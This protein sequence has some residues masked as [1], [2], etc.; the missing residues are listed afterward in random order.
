[1]PEG[2]R[3]VDE[4]PAQPSADQQPWPYP[5]PREEW[6][7]L[8][9][10]IRAYITALRQRLEQLEARLNRNSQNSN[11]PP[12]ADSPF[13]KPASSAQ[14]RLRKPGGRK[15]H[16]GHR[17]AFLAPDRVVDYL[18]ERCRCGGTDIGGLKIYYV[19][20][21]VELPAIQPEVTHHCLHEGTC[22]TCGHTV[23]AS[24]SQ[25]PPIHQCGFGPRMT[26]FVAL[27]AGTLGASR[28]EIQRLLAD[29]FE[30]PVSLG[31]IQKSLDRSSDAVAPHHQAIGDLARAAAA[32][33]IDETSWRSQ[34]GSQVLLRWLWVM[35]NRTVAFFRLLPGRSRKDFEA[36]IGTWAGILISDDYGLYRKWVNLHQS[37]LAHLIRKAQ[38]LAESADPIIA[39][40]G[41]RI[42]TELKLA[43]R[44]A[45]P[46][47]GPPS[48]GQWNAHYM[49]VVALL[50]DHQE[51]TDEA[52]KLARALVRQLDSLWVFLEVHGVDPTNNRAERAL[53]YPVT[54]R[55]HGQGTKSDKGEIWIER[56][57][58]LRETCRLQGQRC[59]PVLVEALSA[60]FE[61]RNPDLSWLP[62]S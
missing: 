8:P 7:Q 32:N 21:Q 43:C 18:P 29:V 51:R 28:R 59:F 16:K 45:R 58:S 15:G 23:Q 40:F 34:R 44:M 6:E 33:H 38:K 54:L 61:G 53:R 42:R 35:S 4:T 25:I 10:G 36:L 57:L 56:I 11:Q 62:V 1:M 13:H 39:H 24:R 41:R 27:M 5:F 26:A 55:Q 60:H 19:H 48:V 9:P 46:G 47:H 14:E 37:C 31:G 30:V 3:P 20:Q 50:F 12:S 2:D 49:R 22:T 17:H 52:G